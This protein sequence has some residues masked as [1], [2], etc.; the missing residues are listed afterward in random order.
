MAV[1]INDIIAKTPTGGTA[2]V[3]AGEYEGPVRI[4]RAM[5]LKGNNTTVWARHGSVLEITAPGVTIEGF[6]VEITEGELSETA[7]SAKYPA[8][9][10]NVEVLGSAEG[11]GEEDG[12]AE[13]PRTL[14]LGELSASE[15]NTFL[16]TVDIP[17]AASI[18]CS[19]PGLRFEPQQL[20][21][22]RS[23]VRITVQGSG[24]AALIYTEILLQSML[25]RRIY[26]SGRFSQNAP[27]VR[28]K[29]LFE[30]RQIDRGSKEQP[31]LPSI[32]AARS[33]ATDVIT[34]VGS[35]PLPDVPALVIKRGQRVPAAAH[36]GDKCS[37]YL[38]GQKLGAV[39]IDPYVFLLDEHERAVGDTGL[40]FFGN[41]QSEDGAVRY[42]KDDGHISVDLSMLSPVIK[43]VTVAY[44]VYSGNA[45]KNFSLI[46]E[47]VLSLF[48]QDKERVQFHIDGLRDEVT[49]VAAEFYIYKGEWRISAVGGGFR[50]G[51]V[52]LCSRYGIEASG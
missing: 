35:A 13:I 14:A 7:I 26:L 34:S 2:A 11:F 49:I 27:A 51:L 8:T 29:V 21:A 31:H 23:E 5:H 10:R 30:A 50:D 33:T 12:A 38:T 3:P 28:D 18:Q 52:K 32:T 42:Y 41:E 9:L 43:R 36:I 37:I 47:P 6:R 40:V 15:E 44:S 4:D 46:R 25:R 1:S 17:A 20:P 19:L 45:Q 16:M 24:S 39:D 22:G 48:A